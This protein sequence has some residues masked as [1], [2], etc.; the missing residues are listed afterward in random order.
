MVRKPPAGL[1]AVSS[2]GLLPHQS[3][4]LI[5]TWED[6][7]C[8]KACVDMEAV[9][10]QSHSDVNVNFRSRHCWLYQLNQLEILT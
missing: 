8:Y 6:A 3:H 7:V 4:S 9:T 10:G 2:L 5:V 1:V